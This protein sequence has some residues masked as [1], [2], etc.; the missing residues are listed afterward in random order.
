MSDVLQ[1]IPPL[2]SKRENG[3]VRLLSCMRKYRQA[4][5]LL[6]P[7]ILFFSVFM[8]VP[9]YGIIIAFKNYNFSKGIIGSEWN[10][11]RHFRV[12]FTNPEFY[13]V[14]RNTLL[15]NIYKL[16][17]SSRPLKA[18]PCSAPGNRKRDRSV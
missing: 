2:V 4:Y 18:F 15:I 13:Q 11:F 16:I 14:F 17:S 3:F 7:G 9:M 12:L 5:L 1:G 6:I 8:Y 10:N